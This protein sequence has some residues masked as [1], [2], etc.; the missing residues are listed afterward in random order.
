MFCARIFGRST[1]S[2]SPFGCTSTNGCRQL[3]LRRLA[4]GVW[5]WRNLSTASGGVRS[6]AD[7]HQTDLIE[8]T[9]AENWRSPLG[10]LHGSAADG[11]G[12][13]IVALGKF[14]ALHR[15]HRSLV[16]QAAQMHG[17]PADGSATVLDG[18]DGG[19]RP[20]VALGKVD[21]PPGSPWL[22]SFS[23]MA[24]ELGSWR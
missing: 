19:G 23:G 18:S 12:R 1:H 15:G 5:R 20:I 9:T 10:S 2:Q 8:E 11:G 22:I 3:A 14:D 17:S 6:C 21:I 16:E 4:H 13:S 24:A 7:V